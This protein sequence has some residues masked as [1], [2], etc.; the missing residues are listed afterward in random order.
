VREI[1]A[2]KMKSPPLACENVPGRL[3][4]VDTIAYR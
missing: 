1:L 4:L 3:A 2:L